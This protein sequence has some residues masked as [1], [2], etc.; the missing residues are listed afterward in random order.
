MKLLLPIL[1]LTSCAIPVNIRNTPER[2]V[3]TA[4]MGV[5]AMQERTESGQVVTTGIHKL[6][7]ELGDVPSAEEY[8]G[9]SS[10]WGTALTAVTQAAGGNYLGAIATAVAAVTG[11]AAA[12]QARKRKQEA[13]AHRA[14][15]CKLAA[16]DPETAKK[17]IDLEGGG[18]V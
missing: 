3:P 7:P 5:V 13:V 15:E 9:D 18:H 14:R 2:P 12:A 4:P 8:E 17:A 1:L 6:N 16:M 11:G 10:F